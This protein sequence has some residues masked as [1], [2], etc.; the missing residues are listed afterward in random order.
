[1]ASVSKKLSGGIA[2]GIAVLAFGASAL[3]E[4]QSNS[5]FTTMAGSW[6]GGGQVRFEGGKSEQIRCNAYYTAKNNGSGLGLAIRCANSGGTRIELRA[7]LAYQGGQVS[8]DWEERS[9]NASGSVTGQASATRIS[10][11]IAGGVSGSM[12]VNFN[13][14][15]QSVSVTTSG[16]TLK[17]LTVNLARSG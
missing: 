4:V 15:S 8:G 11:N 2:A 5:P 14:S 6:S 1:M 13:G 7:S 12:N 16:S 9:Y 10:L 3:A 17:G